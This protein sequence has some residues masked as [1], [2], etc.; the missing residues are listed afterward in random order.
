M[1]ILTQRQG[2]K[3]NLQSKWED[4]C[5]H[6]ASKNF[7]VA[8]YHPPDSSSG[9]YVSSRYK[10]TFFSLFV[11]REASCEWGQN[12]STLFLLYFVPNEVPVQ[13]LWSPTVDPFQRLHTVGRLCC[14]NLTLRIK[15]WKGN[16]EHWFPY[17]DLVGWFFPGQ[18]WM[19]KFI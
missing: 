2:H 17:L 8:S 12:W 6:L 1:C 19:G 18:R 13:L 10:Y 16:L 5:R 3:Q 15:W 11:R 9:S 14:S 4:T 7:M